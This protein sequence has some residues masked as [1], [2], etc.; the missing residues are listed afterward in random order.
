MNQKTKVKVFKDGI[1]VG[2]FK[3]IIPGANAIIGA[4]IYHGFD[5]TK[6]H[7]TEFDNTENIVWRGEK[8][9]I[10]SV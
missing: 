2:W 5:I 8:S 1:E 6:Y 3:D 9:M 4:C 10:E 7:F